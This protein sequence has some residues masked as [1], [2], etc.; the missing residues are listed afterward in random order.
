[1][2]KSRLIYIAS[3]Y[4]LGDA[5]ENTAL[6]CDMAERIRAIGHMPYAP[7]CHST[8]RHFRKAQHY[9]YWIDECLFMVRRCDMLIRIV[10]ESSGADEEEALAHRLDMPV[11]TWTREHIHLLHAEDVEMAFKLMG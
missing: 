10:G 5:Y 1:M 11:L 8:P 2:T 6:Q 9:Q 7:L 4:T 3:P